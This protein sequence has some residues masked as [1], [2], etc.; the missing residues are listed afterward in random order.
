MASAGDRTTW[1]V[2]LLYNLDPSWEAADTTEAQRQAAELEAALRA[3]GHAVTTLTV[4]GHDPGSCLRTCG[5]AEYVVFNWCEDLA[6]VV[7]GDA[8]VAQALEAMGYAY[9]GSPPQALA[10]SWDKPRVKALLTRHGLP[11]PRWQVCETPATDGWD[12]FPAIVKPAREHCSLGVTGE[13]VVLNPDELR[14]RIAFVLDTF[15]QPALVED[16]IDGREFH[17]SLWGNGDVRML[18][19]VEMDFSALGD[20]HD[21]LCTYDSKFSPGSR[22]YE[23]IQLRVPA[24]LAGAEYAALERTSLVAYQAAGC[25]DYARLD[26]RLR[27][28]VF[29]V[30][31]VNPNPDI[32][33]ETSTAYAALAAGLT[34]GRLISQLVELAAERHPLFGA[35]RH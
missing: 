23:Q 16:F 32:G 14:R 27:D 2:L 6:G 24:E 25:R 1:P 28:G 26:I 12:C 22:L 31:D 17:V 11:T 19:P 20:V 7:H 10:L 3:Q 9:T 30:L 5:P 34:Y 29:Y 18:P 21:R 8:V 13:A 35:G 15:R 33:S 4:S